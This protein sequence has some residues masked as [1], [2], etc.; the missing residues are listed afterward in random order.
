MPEAD[1]IQVLLAGRAGVYRVLQNVVGNEPTEEMLEQLSSES[2]R[3]VFLLFGD[4]QTEYGKAVAALQHKAKKCKA[5]GSDA[6]YALESGF[7]RLFVG[8]NPPEAAPWESFYLSGESGLFHKITLEVRNVYRTQG[9]LPAAYPKVADDHLAIELDYLARLAERAEA[10]RASGDLE[11]VSSALN[12][13]EEFLQA[14][15]IKWA[16][17]CADRI[18]VSKYA[19]FYQEVAAVLVEFLPIDLAA[20]DE[21]KAE[22]G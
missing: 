13:S 3:E 1:A 4:K 15:L 16:S 11:K 5:G 21:L 2:T 20:L 12:A 9:L 8:P 19:D 6:L 14:H 18:G 17:K 10:F 22:L 7:A